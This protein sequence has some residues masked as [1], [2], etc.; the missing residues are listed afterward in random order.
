VYRTIVLPFDG[1]EQSTRALP[2]ATALARA[3]GARLI[4]TYVLAPWELVLDV[5]ASLQATATELQSTG[6]DVI[7]QIT[8]RQ[9]NLPGRAILDVARE[10]NAGLIAIG[11]H[12]YGAVGRALFGSVADDVV[13][14]ATVPVLICTSRVGRRWPVDRPRRILVPLDGSA[15]AET[16][17]APARQMAHQF[18]ASLDLVGVVDQT[19]VAVIDLDVQ[20]GDFLGM[21]RA[22]TWAYLEHIADEL[23]NDTLVV[24][25]QA[26]VG[27]PSDTIRQLSVDLDS[28]MIV[29]ATH[30][31][32]GIARLLL[33][34]VALRVL[35]HSGVP[36][37]LV[38]PASVAAE[39]RAEAP[40]L[41]KVVE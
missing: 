3:A 21:Q 33:G 34:S 35:Q 41:G 12:A 40:T 4:L 16:A 10:R 2:Y 20:I 6:I 8:H 23:R 25:V 24:D 9:G 14:H 19:L 39:R 32:S 29:M 18:G 13:R 5:P 27:M 22:E 7:T 26:L 1:S 30:G 15:L 17:L 38:Q 36:V 28:D 31:R 11:T 37:L